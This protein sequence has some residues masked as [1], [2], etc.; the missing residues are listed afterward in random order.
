[1]D[2]CVLALGGSLLTDDSTVFGDWIRGV[3]RILKARSPPMHP[4]VVVVGGGVS[5][6]KGI[7]MVINSTDNPLAHDRV[8]ISATRLNATII[9]ECLSAY[10]IIVAERLPS[11]A[12]EAVE[13]SSNGVVVMGGTHPGHTTDYV[14]IEVASKFSAGNCIIATNV[15]HVYSSDPKVDPDA[16]PMEMVDHE[17]LRQLVGE[18]GDHQAGGRSVV[19]PVGAALA[20]EKKIELSILDG[21]NLVALE[22][23]IIGNK[24]QGT[25]VTNN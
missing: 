18:P 11:S 14:A 4:T 9:R 5:A 20:R 17:T 2:A 15:S 21:K 19:D 1:M 3:A 7:S 6:R 24:F 13:I 22:S 10:G 8:G 12:S 16:M 25:R 23:A